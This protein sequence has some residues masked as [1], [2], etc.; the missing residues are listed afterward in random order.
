MMQERSQAHLQVKTYGNIDIH[1]FSSAAYWIVCICYH[2][3]YDLCVMLILFL[4]HTAS[5][6]VQLQL[7]VALA[8]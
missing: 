6:G 8:I 1:P 2:S 4:F 3:G 7:G 5:C